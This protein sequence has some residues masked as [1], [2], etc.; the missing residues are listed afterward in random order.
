MLSQ[1]IYSKKFSFGKNILYFK[2]FDIII[3]HFSFV[4]N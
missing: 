3:F 1:I 4:A 2:L